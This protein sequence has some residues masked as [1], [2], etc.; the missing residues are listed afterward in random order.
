MPQNT[1]YSQAWYYVLFTVGT[2]KYFLIQLNYFRVAK[3]QISQ[4]H[5]VNPHDQTGW[6]EYEGLK[7]KEAKGQFLT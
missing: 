3:I 2:Q 7:H 4:T 5:S 1:F 6:I